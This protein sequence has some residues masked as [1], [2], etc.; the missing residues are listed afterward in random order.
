MNPE[1]K[2]YFEKGRRYEE[3]VAEQKAEEKFES[4]LICLLER[5]M[6]GEGEMFIP[7][8]DLILAKKRY[9]VFTQKDVSSPSLLLKLVKEV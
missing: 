7:D 1:Q 6:K 9:V 8:T 5:C 2:E 3:M 4:I